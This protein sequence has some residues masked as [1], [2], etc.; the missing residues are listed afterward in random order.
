MSVAEVLSASGSKVGVPCF[1]EA[2]IS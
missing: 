2:T 1:A